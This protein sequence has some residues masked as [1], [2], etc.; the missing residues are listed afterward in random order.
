[1]NTKVRV[2]EGMVKI[3]SKVREDREWK[4][5]VLNKLWNLVRTYVKF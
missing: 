1:M 5:V 4:E 3:Y 2:L